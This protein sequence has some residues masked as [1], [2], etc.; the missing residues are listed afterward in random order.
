M[1]GLSLGAFKTCVIING[2][3]QIWSFTFWYVL[4]VK[5]FGKLFWHWYCAP[6][7]RFAY[8]LWPFE[9]IPVPLLIFCAILIMKNVTVIAA[10]WKLGRGQK[11]SWE[12]WQGLHTWWDHP[13]DVLLFL[14]F[15][16]FK[17]QGMQKEILGHANM[18]VN[19]DNVGNC[20]KE[21]LL[22]EYQKYMRNQACLKYC[23]TFWEPALQSLD[24]LFFRS[25]S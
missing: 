21:I 5:S 11:Q 20:D 17:L 13:E 25:V 23:I 22:V 18:H 15:I 10:I 19:T 2:S 4:K 7:S 12:L 24:W 1:N 9:D 3:I 14:L 8:L 16:Y 6:I